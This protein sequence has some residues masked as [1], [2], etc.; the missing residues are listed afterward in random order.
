MDAPLRAWL[1]VHCGNNLGAEEGL[2]TGSI[3][4]IVGIHEGK[5]VGALVGVCIGDAV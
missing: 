5:L 2:C 1:H 4:G 3:V